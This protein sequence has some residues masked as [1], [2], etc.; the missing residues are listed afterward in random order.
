[1]KSTS[2]NAAEHRI[3]HINLAGGFRG[4]ERQTELLVRELAARNWRQRLVVRSGGALVKRCKDVPG[5]EITEV[6][7][8]P[9]TAAIAGRGCSVVHAHEARAVYSGWLLQRMA[10][11]PYV[12]TRR[13]DHAAGSSLP[14]TSAYRSASKVVA[15]SSSIA[16][17]VEA[18]YPDIE[19]EVVPD[20]HADMLN[21]YANGAG[22]RK[23]TDKT[24]GKTVVGHIG[25]LDHSHK[26]QG[27]IIEAARAMKDSH[28]NLHFVLVG[29]G[30]D[31][32]KFRR[33]A[34]GLGNVEFV[35]FVDNVADYLA[36]F[37]VFIYPSLR[38]GLGSSLLDAMHFGLPIVASEVGGIP[39]I[40]EHQVNGLLIPPASPREL[41]A[42][43]ERV[44]ADAGL[45][46]SMRQHNRN[47]AAQFG[48]ARMATSYESIYRSILNGA[49]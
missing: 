48:A 28:P 46:E 14:R 1:M 15:I 38:E 40:V 4:G 18:H 31:D 42:A 2:P 6:L 45:R 19:C 17:T 30:K 9:I 25:E 22:R 32:R 27:T 43:I 29:N 33:T 16:R 8:H 13:I 23:S 36:T 37:D 35:G 12:L 44:V 49:H 5:L 26:G 11:T 10:K 3:C 20:A 41:I 34:S 47:K 21:G 7:A 39:E 24:T